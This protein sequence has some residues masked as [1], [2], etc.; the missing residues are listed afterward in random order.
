MD[1]ASGLNPEVWSLGTKRDSEKAKGERPLGIVC[2]HA[3]L[4]QLCLTLCNPMDHSLPGASVHGILLARILEFPCPPPGDLPDPGLNP[5]LLCL[6][7][8]QAG[9][10]PLTP[11]G[12][13]SLSEVD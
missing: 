1:G 13:L 6:L 9:S 11:P 7:H 12:V 3:K 8:W 4:L 2:T 10:L 5:H